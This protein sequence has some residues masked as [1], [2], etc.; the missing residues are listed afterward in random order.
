ME[1]SKK[2]LFDCSWSARVYGDFYKALDHRSIILKNHERSVLNNKAVIEQLKAT[3][4]GGA[5]S[6]TWLSS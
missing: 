3:C 6:Q 5:L 1:A 2:R 4:P